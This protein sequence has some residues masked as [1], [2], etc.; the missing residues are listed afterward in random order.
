MIRASHATRRL[1]FLRSKA[2]PSGGLSSGLLSPSFTPSKVPEGLLE[3]C[4]GCIYDFEANKLKS[5]QERI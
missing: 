3:L 5:S 4:Q 1:R 2:M